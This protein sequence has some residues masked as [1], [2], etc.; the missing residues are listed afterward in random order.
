MDITSKCIH[1]SYMTGPVVLKRVFCKYKIMLL[2]FIYFPC[3][4][5]KIYCSQLIVYLQ[6]KTLVM[7]TYT[8][9]YIKNNA[10]EVLI[11]NVLLNCVDLKVIIN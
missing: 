3:L 11:T 9:N 5:H 6:T 4:F 2:S 10:K 1:I 7:K 8:L